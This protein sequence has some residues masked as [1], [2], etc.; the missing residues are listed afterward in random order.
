MLRAN[1]AGFDSREVILLYFVFNIVA[2]ILSYPIGRLSDKIGRKYTLS[3][4]YLLY[5][6]VYLGI[7]LL[8][9]RFAFWSLFVVYGIYTA[10]T[11]G[12]ERALVS[13]ISPKHL[14]ASTLGLHSAIVGVGLLP[15]SIIAGL[16]WDG[17]GQ[18]VPFVFGGCL[19]I[20]ASMAVFITLNMKVKALSS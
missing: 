1:A 11:V 16:L 13:E 17:F 15:A 4:G 5:G 19:A 14:K 12:G 20:F 7:G 6:L 9:T 8:S 3:V 10:L 18:A 2:S